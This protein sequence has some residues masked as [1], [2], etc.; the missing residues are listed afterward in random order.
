MTTENL[1]LPEMLE[2][3]GAKHITHNE[4][5]QMLDVFVAAVL[6]SRTV[7]NP[8]LEPVLG[9][10]Y[11]IP[12]GAIDDWS[13]NIGKI[14]HWYNNQ[15]Y[16]Y[17]TPDFW[18]AYF[19]DESLSYRFNG[20]TWDAVQSG[21]S[22]SEFGL[23]TSAKFITVTNY[24][25]LDQLETGFYST[26]HSDTSA[27]TNKPAFKQSTNVN[28]LIKVFKE[29]DRFSVEA[30]ETKRNDSRH[31]REKV[32]A[33]SWASWR[34]LWAEIAAAAASG[35]GSGGSLTAS[36]VKTLYESN[37]DTNAF[38][39]AEEL[40]LSGI[41]S[42]AQVNPN[43]AGVKTLYESNANTNAFTDAE[44]TKLSELENVSVTGKAYADMTAGNV[45]L[46][47]TQSNNPVIQIGGTPGTTRTLTLEALERMW[48]VTNDSDGGCTLTTGAGGTVFLEAG[49]Q[50]VVFGDG[51][52]VRAAITIAP[53][54]LK[55]NGD[56]IL[57]IFSVASLPDPSTR[58]MVT[59]GC[60]DGDSGSP[61]LAVSDGGSWKRISLGAT[62]S[63]T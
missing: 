19:E 43:A 36:E 39:D 7:T 31:F 49:F 57:P 21:G 55:M 32:S 23:G 44:K 1:K 12:D 2:S 62:V 46:N 37:A 60:T 6:K 16:Y 51:V 53:N 52:G 13:T 22:A 50:Y 47:A 58:Y 20:T 41:Q 28:V 26:F 63:S 29:S 3:Q 34:D 38:T 30:I 48:V 11:F 5:L 56:L 27:V 18:L 25:E 45:T 17:P 35:G 54:G 40:K 33:S 59:V 42:G 61:C 9:D 14:A 8:P 10:A 4:A 15:W 24:D